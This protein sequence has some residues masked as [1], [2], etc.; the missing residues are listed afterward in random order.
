[1]L[2]SA[3]LTS[4]ERPARHTQI[5]IEIAALACLTTR[6]FLPWRLSDAGPGACGIVAMGRH[7]KPFTQAVM[8]RRGQPLLGRHGKNWPI[9][10]AKSLGVAPPFPIRN[11]QN[12]N[13]AD[14][15]DREA[16]RQPPVGAIDERVGD[17][18]DVR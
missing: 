13:A 7:P 9:S 15:V 3:L 2:R 8:A 5:T 12:G 1:M 11:R 18:G 10:T 16:G 6:G 17:G 4:I 14:C